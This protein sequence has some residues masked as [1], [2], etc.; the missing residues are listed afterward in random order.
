MT[1]LENDSNFKRVD[2][3]IGTSFFNAKMLSSYSD[4]TIGAHKKSLDDKD[5]QYIDADKIREDGKIRWQFVKTYKVQLLKPSE[6]AHAL[7]NFIREFRLKNPHAE[8]TI[9]LNSGHIRQMTVFAIPRN[10]K[11]YRVR[12]STIL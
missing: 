9:Y 5:V 1:N 3:V 10:N 7:N 12:Y 11:V 8:F 6:L 2:G 4:I